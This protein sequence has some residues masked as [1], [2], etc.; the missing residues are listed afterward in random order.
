ML[1]KAD[2]KELTPDYKLAYV[3]VFLLIVEPLSFYYFLT[4]RSSFDKEQLIFT[5][6]LRRTET[7]KQLSTVSLYLC[8]FV[9]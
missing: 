5:R 1:F 4:A 9:G 2:Y 6:M 3:C 8:K 7:V